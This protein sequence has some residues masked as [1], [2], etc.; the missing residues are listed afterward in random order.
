MISY[1]D[2]CKFNV[3][4]FYLDFEMN[5]IHFLF[6]FS[7]YFLFLL[8]FFFHYF[9]LILIVRIIFLFFLLICIFDPSVSCIIK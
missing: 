7:Y 2:C 4:N 9:F 5:F 6:I 1:F 3:S 8:D